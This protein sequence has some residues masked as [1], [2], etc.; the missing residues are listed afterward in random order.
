MRPAFEERDI[1]LPQA[2]GHENVLRPVRSKQVDVAYR[3]LF[4]QVCEERDDDGVDRAAAIVHGE[5]RHFGRGH[6]R[7]FVNRVVYLLDRR[8]H[9]LVEK[10]TAIGKAH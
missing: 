3:G 9:P 5:M 7:R 6:A 4:V 1:G 8:P 2:Q 10:T